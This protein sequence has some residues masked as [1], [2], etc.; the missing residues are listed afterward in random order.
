MGGC[1]KWDAVYMWGRAA[2][3]P[4]LSLVA[5]RIT[6]IPV[7]WVELLK[8]HGRDIQTEMAYM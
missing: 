7:A 6:N 8:Y 1:V 3:V 4:S 5:P 2:A